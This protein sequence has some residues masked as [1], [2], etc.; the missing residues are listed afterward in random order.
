VRILWITNDLPPDS[1]GIERF[2]AELVR[3]TDPQQALV[4]GPAGRDAAAWDAVQPFTVRRWRGPVLPVPAVR[5]WVIDAARHHRPDVV[6][7]GAA[8]PLGAL[9]TA[10]RRALG[11]PIVAL[12]HGLEAGLAQ[13]GLRGLVRRSLRGL[14]AVTT[15]S[16]WTE[17]A[18]APALAGVTTAR[19]APGVDLERFAPDPRAGSELRTAWGIADTDPVIGCVSRLVRRKGQDRLVANW[20]RIR[21]RHP[22]A[23]LVIAGDGPLERRLRADRRVRGQ[24]SRILVTGAVGWDR[25]PACYAAFDLFAMP[26]R[27]RLGGTDV[28]G[29]GIV[30]LEAQAAGVPVVAGRSG[31][32]P[33]ALVD[34]TTGT[35]VDGRDDDAL[36]GA[37]DRWLADPSA[38][39][40]AGAAGR[41]WVEER[42][43]W[44]AAADRFADV[45]EGAVSAG[46]GGDARSD[47]GP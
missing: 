15:I 5:R 29:L 39:A 25:L 20:D 35:V 41:R 46:P 9:G 23:W 21:T 26:C 22:D 40:R 45:L 37:I 33:E 47:V 19:V 34:G 18:L 6:V 10:L 4:L 28:E 27:T 11:I 14:D 17:R 44:D 38:R 42:W 36:V 24:T 43:S 3:R 12:T 30:Y 13:A 2:V 32:A 16:D 1:G 31:G 7:L 8:W